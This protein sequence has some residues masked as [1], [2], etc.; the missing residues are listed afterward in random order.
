[1][2]ASKLSFTDILFKPHF[3]FTGKFLSFPADFRT[4]QGKDVR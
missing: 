4:S 3:I 2:A 1:M